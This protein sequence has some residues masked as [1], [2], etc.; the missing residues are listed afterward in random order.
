MDTSD[1]KLKPENLKD[2]VPPMGYCI[3]SNTIAVDGL[4]VGFM[5]REEP[6]DNNDSG[7]RFLSGKESQLYADNPK[8]SQQLEVNVVANLDAAIIPYLTLPFGTDMERK[9]GSDDFR[10][11]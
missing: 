5:Y 10:K 4:K 1:L 2:L 3:V 8:N 9:E 11:I 6:D 7:W